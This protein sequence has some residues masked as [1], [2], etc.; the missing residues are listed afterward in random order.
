MATSKKREIVILTIENNLDK[1]KM[2]SKSTILIIGNKVKFEAYFLE[3]W[4]Y[5]RETSP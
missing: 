3:H 2:Y 4:C 1:K 5:R